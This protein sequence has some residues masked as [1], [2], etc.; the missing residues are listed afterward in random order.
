M[1]RERIISADSHVLI[2]D[3]AVLENLASKFHD[4]YKAAR[5]AFMQLM[6]SRMK[7]RPDAES[8]MPSQDQPWEAAGR[9][10]E[11]DPAARLADMDTDKVDAEVLYT[12]VMVGA[13]YY[14]MSPE[15]RIASFR[16]YNDAALDFAS[17]D[18]KRLLP[19]YIVPIADMDESVQE[20]TRL[21]REGVLLKLSKQN[22]KD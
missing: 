6:A 3:E 5:L 15:A 17:S 10:G 14:E 16:A 7:K 11:W 8:L 18:P 20:V 2:R 13:G 21:R 12:D 4:D 22:V 9:D 19:V 1:A